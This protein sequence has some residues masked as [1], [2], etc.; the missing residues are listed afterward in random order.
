MKLQKV[1]WME[2]VPSLKHSGGTMSEKGFALQI[3]N[4]NTCC[5]GWHFQKENPQ[6]FSHPPILPNL[7][8]SCLVQYEIIPPVKLTLL[9][10]EPDAVR[11]R[12]SSPLSS[13][14]C[15]VDMFECQLCI[16]IKSKIFYWNVT[17]ASK[18]NVVLH[19]NSY[20][21]NYTYTR[22]LRSAKSSIKSNNWLMS[23]VMEG[24]FGFILLRC[25]SYIL[26]TPGE[27][28]NDMLNGSKNNN[29]NKMQSTGK[30]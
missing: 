6:I 22:Q 4:T 1:A 24:L 29:N 9:L 28:A 3:T 13:L 17:N 21:A 19:S 2:K 15:M 23:Y 27:E 5:Q 8:S 20:T 11:G 25:S 26:Q 14:C 18:G 12:I 16:C 30:S 7:S 10:A